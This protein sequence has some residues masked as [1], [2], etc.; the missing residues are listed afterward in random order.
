MN[1]RIC[2]NTLPAPETY[3]GSRLRWLVLF[4]A[5]IEVAL[6]SMYYGWSPIQYVM[7]REGYFKEFCQAGP[8]NR[9]GGNITDTNYGKV[10][11]MSRDL[12]FSGIFI[13]A[14][15]GKA[16]TAYLMGAIWDSRGTFFVRMVAGGCWS[17]ACFLGIWARPEAVRSDR[18]YFLMDPGLNIASSNSSSISFLSPMC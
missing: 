15:L 8:W 13:A 11:T 17:F 9:D 5:M 1:H 3:I 2:C 12:V 4:T 6:C 10:C 7:K 14:E 16:L 18:L